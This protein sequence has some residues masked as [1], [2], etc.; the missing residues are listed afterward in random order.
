MP[1]GRNRGLVD[2]IIL[3]LRSSGRDQPCTAVG[4]TAALPCGFVLLARGIAV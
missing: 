2:T 1:A 4:L 3:G